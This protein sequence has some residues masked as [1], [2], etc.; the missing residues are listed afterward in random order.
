MKWDVVIIAAS[1]ILIAFS[2]YKLGK[3]KG[4]DCE[5]K[6][7]RELLDTALLTMNEQQV[8]IRRME[9]LLKLNQGLLDVAPRIFKNRGTPSNVIPLV[10]DETV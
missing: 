6:R 3:I 5:W 1:Q 2:A 8:I 10:P 4:A 9:R 7:W